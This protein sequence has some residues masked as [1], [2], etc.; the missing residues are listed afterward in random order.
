MSENLDELYKE[1]C[2]AISARDYEC[3]RSLLKRILFIDED[4][5]DASRLLAQIVGQQRKRW[6]NGLQLWGILG[7]V[8]LVSFAIYFI[9]R[10]QVFFASQSPSA[11][12]TPWSA[13]QSPSLTIPPPSTSQPSISTMVTRTTIAAFTPTPFPFEWKRI[14][15][16]QEFTRD[17]VTAIAVDPTDPD[18]IYVGTTNA[19]IFKSID[20]GL[21]WRPAQKDLGRALIH[22]LVF[23]S[24]DSNTLY[25]GTSLGGVYKTTDGGMNWIATNKGIKSSGWEWVS[26]VVNNPNHGGGLL[27]THADGI[28]TTTDGGRNWEL[29][30]AKGG[31]GKTC[32]DQ[33]VGLV[34]HPQDSSI[35]FMLNRAREEG[36]CLHGIYHSQDGGASWSFM[37]SPEG[38]IPR[39]NALYIDQKT[40]NTLVALYYS[41]A[42]HYSE[43]LYVSNNGGQEWNGIPI[44][45]EAIGLDEQEL[46]TI[47]CASGDEFQKSTDGGEKWEVIAS[48]STK[49]SAI[50]I[51]SQA[52]IL[53]GQGLW[54]STDGGA[55]WEERN[56]G[57]G[58]G[59]LE[60]RADPVQNSTLYLDDVS[61][62]PYQS[63][64]GG[65]NWQAVREWGCGMNMSLD[66]K[67]WG[68]TDRQIIYA[69]NDAGQTWEEHILPA[70][71]RIT[72]VVPH[73]TI[74]GRLYAICEEDAPSC[75]AISSD[76]G[77]TWDV[78]NEIEKLVDGKLYFDH[79]QG[80][81]VYAFS[82]D[83]NVYVSN[84]AGETWRAYYT[85]SI[86][87]L[88]ASRAVVDPRD[89]ERLFLA[90]RGDGILISVNGCHSWRKSNEGLDSLFM[91]AITFNPSNPDILYA[92]TDGGAYISFN[93]GESWNEINEGLLGATVVYSIVADTESNVY[94][95]TPYGIFKLE[96]K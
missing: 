81:R 45:C 75:V 47:Y 38:M 44:G 67:L 25:A 90:T 32:P 62:Q 31:E 50:A 42:K 14:S 20:G 73:P 37:G 29:V 17:T 24:A 61:C 70:G 2:A 5:E 71:E 35:I 88:G 48:L 80:Q 1:A 63:L 65:R 21:S 28:Y 68:W 79:D 7:A 72:E 13:S 22:T 55:T 11:A 69:S 51:S 94:A 26:I 85:E 89:A 49:A 54:I 84:D 39:F 87:A 59:H 41:E 8:L 10:L 4:Y 19:G 52:I 60:L 40:G 16:G 83:F 82:R 6:F 53:G 95:A 30:L 77:V 36:P 74:S 27:Y 58:A 23:D 34:V 33:P 43:T 93:G 92:G 86:N 12:V 46:A 78:N 56:N 91:N 15:I 18:V 96:R 76:F 9:P 64:D 57:L 66:G 3:A